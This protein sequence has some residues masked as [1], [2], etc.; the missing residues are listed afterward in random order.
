[1]GVRL[2]IMPVTKLSIFVC[3]IAKRKAGKKMPIIP[4]ANNLM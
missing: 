3:A 2:F 4:E 1:M